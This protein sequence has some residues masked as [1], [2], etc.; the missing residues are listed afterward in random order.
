MTT[1][2]I[3]TGYDDV[4]APIGAVCERSMR[5]YSAI[6]GFDFQSYTFIAS[7]RPHAWKK[8]RRLMNEIRYGCHEFILWVDADAC[9]VRGDANILDCVKPDKDFYIVKHVGSIPFGE[10]PVSVC[11]ERPNTGVILVR[12][13]EWSLSLL[14]SIYDNDKWTG[15][16]WWENA[17]FMDIL[18]YRYEL[19]GGKDEDK[20]DGCLMQRIDWLPGE[21]NWIKGVSAG[22]PIIYHLAGLSNEKRLA[23]LPDMKFAEIPLA[24]IRGE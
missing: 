24:T 2:K 5:I 18:G 13:C 4:F 10:T 9:F 21:W 17:S 12:S 3:I 16:I 6:H 11:V 20:P 8:I 14:Q 7:G 19:S 22:N 1:L 23:A 15:H